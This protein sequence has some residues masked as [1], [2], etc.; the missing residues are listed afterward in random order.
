M[1]SHV[2][3]RA[4]TMSWTLRKS[5][6]LSAVRD[7]AGW[8]AASIVSPLLQPCKIRVI[9]SAER[10]R[11]MVHCLDLRHLFRRTPSPWL[12]RYLDRCGVFSGIDWESVSVRNITP[13]MDGWLSLDTDVQGR[14]AE[15]FSN[16]KLLATPAGKVQIIDEARHHGLDNEVSA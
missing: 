1:D 13:L 14:L 6:T 10:A 15:D 5:E 16:I 8:S 3:S 7:W 9:R 12:R 11:S 4:T 2:P